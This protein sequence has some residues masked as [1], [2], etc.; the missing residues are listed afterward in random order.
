[1]S[2]T[3]ARAVLGCFITILNSGAYAASGQGAAVFFGRSDML[4]S[5]PS[6]SST[7]LP[8]REFRNSFEATI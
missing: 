6:V 2:R 3:T 7:D 1:M 8:R 5:T 4:S